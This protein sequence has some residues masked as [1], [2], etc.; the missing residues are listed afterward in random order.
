MQQIIS[1]FSTAGASPAITGQVILTARAIVA[2]PDAD[3]PPSLRRWAWA[4][5]K[6][7][8]GQTISQTGLN[9]LTGPHTPTQGRAT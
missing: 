4:V 8:R 7:T 9:R 2:R 1:S 3:R 6:S 5:L